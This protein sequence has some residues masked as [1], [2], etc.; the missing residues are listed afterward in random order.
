MRRP[1]WIRRYVRRSGD[2][3]TYAL[4]TWRGTFGFSIWRRGAF[5]LLA[6][7]GHDGVP[8]QIVFG[9]WWG[10]LRERARR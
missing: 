2:S 5:S 7:L 1:R 8:V 3:A 6:P 10:P 4:A 9:D